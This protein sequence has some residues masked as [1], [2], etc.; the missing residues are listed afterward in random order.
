MLAY[1]SPWHTAVQA[2][3]GDDGVPSLAGG[4]RVNGELARMESRHPRVL[5]LVGILLVAV[6]LRTAVASISPIVREISDDIP[7]DVL[8]LGVIGMV[9]PVAFALAGL[10]GSSVARRLGIE[11]FLVVAIA[12]MTIGH[13]VRVGAGGFFG[14]LLGG[15]LSL[16][17]M[18]V[19]NVLLP[20]LVKKYFNDRVGVVTALYMTFLTLSATIPSLLSAPIA[21]AT[22][23]RAAM[24]TWAVLAAVSAIPWLVLRGRLGRARARS[25]EQL[26]PPA[27]PTHLPV[28]VWRS[29]IAWAIAVTSA[30]SSLNFFIMFAWLPELLIETAHVSITQAGALLALFSVMGLPAS[31][32]I[33]NLAVRLR[34]VGLLVQLGAVLFLGGYAGLLLAPAGLPWLWVAMVG[35]GQLTFP[36]VLVLINL[37][38][39]STTGSVALSGFAQGFGYAVAASGPLVASMLRELTGGWSALYGLLMASTLAIFITGYVL[40]T[41]GTVEEELESHHERKVP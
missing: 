31:L 8:Q 9:P 27:L 24:L 35:G 10:L 2:V 41:P 3:R 22:H 34:N 14:L 32:L 11:R 18:G 4:R 29:R 23:W 5:V 25:D 40:R 30:V 6:N 13:L 33:P 38:T 20:P 7:L 1:G 39:R 37:R 16:L 12:L 15:V 28:P 26:I 36:L 19:G 21:S 17:G